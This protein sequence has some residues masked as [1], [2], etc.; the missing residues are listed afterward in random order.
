V[1]GFTVFTGFF[2]NMKS[3]EPHNGHGKGAKAR[4]VRSKEAANGP[5]P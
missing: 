1:T 5:F 2:G 4:D 3:T